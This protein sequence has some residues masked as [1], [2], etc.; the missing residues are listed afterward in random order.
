M[1]INFLIKKRNVKTRRRIIKQFL[2]FNYVLY[3]Y[4]KIRVNKKYKK[5]F[6]K[7][8]VKKPAS[9]QRVFYLKVHRLHK[10]AF[11]CIQHWVNIAYELNAFIYFVC[12]NPQMEK[13]IYQKIYFGNFNFEFI[14]SDRTTLK[15]CIQTILN[16]VDR[17]KMWQRIGYA[18]TTAF[19]H[20]Y[21]NKYKL[22]Y[23]IDADD[24]LLFLDAKTAA[25]A[26]IQAEEYAKK[27]KLDLFNLDMFVSKSFGTHWSF[28]VVMC[29]SSEN[30]IN[31]IEK[32][33]NW[34]NNK[35]F[36]KKY[37]TFYL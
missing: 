30:C 35:R 23:N 16:K 6:I 28:G 37:K 36:I 32:N 24:I 18:M 8:E 27:N 9:N 10:T 33:V 26:F 21:K 25:K 7:K 17:R 2:F 4:T 5:Q 13:E 19:A 3:Q 1:K 15:K 34:R 20:A 14:K 11:D 22:F 31:A 29:L 12:D